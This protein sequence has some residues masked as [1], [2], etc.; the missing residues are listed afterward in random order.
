MELKSSVFDLSKDKVAD[1]A[2]SDLALIV[3][4]FACSYS[5]FAIIKSGL[6]FIDILIAEFNFSGK[7]TSLIDPLSNDSGSLMPVSYTH[8]TLPT[9]A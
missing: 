6:F 7:V 3:S 9:K 4:F 2:K 1:G 8:L 5:S